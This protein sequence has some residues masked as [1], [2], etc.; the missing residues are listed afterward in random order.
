M[1]LT[2]VTLMPLP[3]VH[4]YKDRHGRD[5]FYLRRRGHKRI[6]IIG[7]PGTPEFLASYRNAMDA[8]GA[9]VGKPPLAGSLNALAVSWYASSL[10]KQ[11]GPSTSRVYRNILERVRAEHGN[12]PVRLLEGQH[13]RRI[14]AAKSDTPAAANHVLRIFRMLMAH[15]VE[16]GWRKDNPTLGVRKLK[17]I[18]SGARSWTDEHIAAYQAHWPVGTKQ[19][20]ALALLLYTGQRRSDIVHMGRQHAR[21]G[22]MNVRQVKTKAELFIPI[23]PHLQAHLDALPAGHLTYMLT[24]QGKPYTP[25]GF[26]NAFKDWACAAG[27]EA[28]LTPHGLRKAAARRMA[29]GGCTA[30]QIAA[31]TGHK[32]LAEV[33][34][35][36]RAVDQ[37]QLARSAVLRMT[38]DKPETKSG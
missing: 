22:G 26:T 9:P 14:L 4:G 18:G 35:Y 5:R 16:E 20:L 10:F 13:I 7:K 3:F 36:T 21:S 8:T 1:G 37:E 17:E 11:L 30:H 15:A 33:E 19:G 32:T 24:D 25:P 23:H 2:A 29:E 34:R 28:G 12:K 38:R 31:I 6:A 27:L